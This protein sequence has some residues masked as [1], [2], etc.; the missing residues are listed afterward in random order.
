VKQ[1][2]LRL[3]DDLA[4]QAE[5]VARVRGT[6]LNALVIDALRAEL[7]RAGS[8]KRFTSQAREALKRD[9][10]ALKRLAQ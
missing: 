8:D 5:I 7:E 9:K 1:T 3:P 2:T 10:N 4:A 6:S